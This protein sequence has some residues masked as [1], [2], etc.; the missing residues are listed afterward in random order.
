MIPLRQ[1]LFRNYQFAFE[2]GKTLHLP[3]GICCSGYVLEDDKC[4]PLAPRATISGHTDSGPSH[5]SQTRI[6]MVFMATTSRTGPNCEKH[7][8]SDLFNTAAER[9]SVHQPPTNTHAHP[10]LLAIFPGRAGWV[11][12]QSVVTLPP[13]HPRNN[14]N[15]KFKYH[16]IR[17]PLRA[18]VPPLQ[19]N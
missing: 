19:T 11:L 1:A 16:Q 7:S 6:F 15:R 9:G 13:T 14:P 2:E 4:L 18:A 12:S 10:C 3:Q 17:C 8:Y 5:G